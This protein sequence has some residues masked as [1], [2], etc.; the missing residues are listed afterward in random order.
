VRGEKVLRLTDKAVP[1]VV[2]DSQVVMTLRQA[3]RDE[4]MG[5]RGVC[6]G[7][8]AGIKYGAHEDSRGVADR[9][10]PIRAV[11]IFA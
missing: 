4:A 11:I 8:T 10:Q 6:G 5:C 9:H 7:P 3:E 1:A 2:Y